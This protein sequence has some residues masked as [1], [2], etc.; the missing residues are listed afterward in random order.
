MYPSEPIKQAY[1]IVIGDGDIGKLVTL[2]AD[3]YQLPDRFIVYVD[4]V[5][6]IDTGYIGQF[7]YRN[8]GYL[9]NTIGSFSRGKFTESLFRKID[10][11]T[12]KIY[13]FVDQSHLSDG[14]PRV[15]VNNTPSVFSFTKATRTNVAYVDVYGPMNY[16]GL[17]LPDGEV[18]NWITKW[19]FNLRC[20]GLT[21][22]PTPTRTQTPTK[23]PTRTQTPTKTPT[24]TP[25]ISTTPTNTPTRTQTPTNT[26]T[27]TN[28]QTPTNTQTRTQTPTNTST[29]TQTPTQ[30][31][32]QTEPRG[33][34]VYGYN[35]PCDTLV[36]NGQYKSIAL[37]RQV[38][39]CDKPLDLVLV[40]DDSGSIGISNFRIMRDSIKKLIALLKPNMA[41]NTSSS[42]G[43]LVGIAKFATEAYTVSTLSNNT[44]ELHASID[45]IVHSF[46][47]TNLYAG[48]LEANEILLGSS[49]NRS[50]VTK[51]IIVF[52][53]GDPNRP[54]RNPSLG[55]NEDGRFFAENAAKQLKDDGVE[56]I[57]VGI[58]LN[59]NQG[60]VN[61]LKDVIASRPELAYYSSEFQLTDEF[62]NN[63]LKASCE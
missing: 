18:D 9:W 48:L 26:Q 32:T 59:S 40:I 51:K 53:D 28:T 12:K 43:L 7:Q 57:V 39:S 52:T 29:N 63:L 54:L 31:P 30:T 36:V 19:E 24:N 22:T 8:R 49:V 44:T 45:N 13:P 16:K 38:C 14:Y 3:S 60:A 27:S 61:F 41:V 62:I 35:C 37:C 50:E 58:N 2:Q 46:G 47:V 55:D 11:I 6:V 56:I 4:G 33:E 25:T 42:V 17:V 15:L 23:T 1:C 5:V 20:P 34:V 21:P 10:P